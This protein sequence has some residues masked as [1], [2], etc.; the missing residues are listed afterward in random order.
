MF[1]K[2]QNTPNPDSLKFLPEGIVLE[3]GTADFPNAKAA[4]ASPLAKKL[5]RVDGIKG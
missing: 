1:I 5:F 3:T 2:T 4:L